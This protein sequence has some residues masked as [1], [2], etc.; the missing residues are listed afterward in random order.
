VNQRWAASTAR[1][2]GLAGSLDFTITRVGQTLHIPCAKGDHHV[3]VKISP[4][5]H[6]EGVAK[7]MLAKGWT[8]GRTMTCP[9]CQRPKRDK[10]MHT[11]PTTSTIPA[12]PAVAA[13]PSE[14]AKRA[15]RM[16]FMALEDYYD[17]GAKRYKPGY[18][19]A[20]IAETTGAAVAY[21]VKI[22]SEYFGGLAE[23]TEVADLKAQLAIA[24]ADI[25]ATGDAL[26]KRLETIDA[27]LSRICTAQG[28]PA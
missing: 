24:R 19:D 21:V 8:I 13:S 5:L 26:V 28:W 10:S 4:G 20:K 7:A 18:T 11:K 3:D 23:P 14:S 17:E 6:P 1:K 2:L 15:H 22:R 9:N 16:V 27:R 25:A 12:E